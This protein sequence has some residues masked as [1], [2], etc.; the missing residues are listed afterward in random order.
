[1]K[2]IIGLLTLIAVF[3]LLPNLSQAQVQEDSSSSDT[4][5]LS[6][7]EISFRDS[8]AAVNEM[9]RIRSEA[10]TF[11][12]KGIELYSK[13]DFSGADKKLSQ[14]IALLSDFPEAWYNRA[15]ARA[16]LK[17]FD[18]AFADLDSALV[19]QPENAEI[20]AIR[21]GMLMEAGRYADA[22]TVLSKIIGANPKDK[23]ALHQR[24]TAY[25]ILGSIEEAAA[26][27]QKASSLDASFA[28]AWN[29]LASAYRKMGQADKAIGFLQQ[30]LKAEPGAAY[31][32]NNMG[33]SLRVLDRNEEALHYYSEAIRADHSYVLA[34]VNQAGLLIEMERYPEAE[35]LSQK[36]MQLFPEDPGIWNIRGILYRKS[37]ETDES[38]KALDKAITLDPAYAT[39]YLNRAISREEAGD[40][41]GACQDYRKAS[42]LGL[43]V[44]K[45]YL[46]RECN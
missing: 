22:I 6:A 7:E 35:A 36:T 33:S 41:N 46:D 38:I 1:M 14:A 34:Y 23:I 37:G 30:G 10:M 32:L 8:I 25:Y 5:A 15:I 3:S 42:D 16:S 40:G 29:D 4:S 26:D 39:A 24:G 2:R 17:N 45:K 9:S 19:Y 20:P 12:N 28:A 43:E 31:I 21:S 13:E 11:Y 18:A 44:A 27:F